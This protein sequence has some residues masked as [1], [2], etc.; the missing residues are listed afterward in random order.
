MKGI[1]LAVECKRPRND[2]A[3]TPQPVT[4]W[5][6]FQ[7]TLAV[8]LHI[9]FVIDVGCEIQ[10]QTETQLSEGVCGWEEFGQIT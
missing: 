10:Y 9:L 4:Q 2:P 7:A 1:L 8:E 6:V 3:G 5:G